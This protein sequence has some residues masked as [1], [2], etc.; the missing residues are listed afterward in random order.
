VGS[1]A[2]HFAGGRDERLRRFSLHM[3]CKEGR[4]HGR[5]FY[6]TRFLA[7]DIDRRPG[8][9]PGSLRERYQGCRRA[10]GSEPVVVRSP[11]RGLHLFFPLAVPVSTLGLSQTFRS[12]LPVLIPAALQA[13]GLKVRPGWIEVFPTSKHTLRMPLASGTTQLDSHTLAPLS[14]VS[15]GDEITRLVASMDRIAGSNPLDV[16]ALAERCRPPSPCRGS[17]CAPRAPALSTPTSAR[18]VTRSTGRV[19]QIDVDRLE[20]EGL[21]DGVTRNA[22]AMALASRKMLMLGWNEDSTVE[23]LMHWT[24]TMT[25]G[26]S[27]TA[28]RLPHAAAEVKLRNEYVRICR[29]IER[30][31]ATGKVVARI[32]GGVGRPITAAE[33]RWAFSWTSSIDDP[34]ERYR[35]EVFL[36]CIMGFAKDRG[37][38]AIGPGRFAGSDLIHAQVSSKMMERWPFCGS[39]GYRRRLDWAER[40]GFTRMVLNYRHSQDPTRSRARTFEL[41]VEMDGLSAVG[42]NSGAL[43]HAARAAQQPGCHTVHARQVEH[44]LYAQRE[45]GS[46]FGEQYGQVDGEL[47]GQLVGAYEA[48]LAAGTAAIARAA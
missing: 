10:L 8:Q 2:A 22:A 33:A 11:R 1:L 15:R 36:F 25:N 42:V 3:H 46:A 45:Y 24:S 21:Q 27:S 43:L 17:K 9:P 48:A 40:S 14:V 35:V 37:R 19:G 34:S 39:G 23:F 20:Q 12:D 30:G 26:L 38:V 41:E 44:A 6:W 29:G 32:G 47:V 31:L 13:A 7:I 28:A 16:F 4:L 18:I 5:P